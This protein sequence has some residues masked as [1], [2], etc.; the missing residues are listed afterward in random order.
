M[1]QKNNSPRLAAYVVWVP[2]LGAHENNVQS[3][4]TLV[5]DSRAR[6][7]WDPDEVLGRWYGRTLPTPGAAWDVYLLFGP[8]ASWVADKPPKPDFWMHQLGGVTVAPRLDANV[9][10]QR[11]AE[12][13]AI[14]PG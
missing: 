4:T 12:L 9:F 3:A 7:Y 10:A 11:A 5:P 1:L 2:E 6:Q 13:L 8:Q 14:P